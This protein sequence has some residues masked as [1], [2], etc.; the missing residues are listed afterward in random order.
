MKVTAE[1][2]RSGGWWAISVPEVPGAFTQTKRLDQV[3]AMVA[4]AVRLMFDDDA[5]DVD[6]EVV[7]HTE[8]D[9][10]LRRTMEARAEA[11]GAAARAAALTAEAAVV[12]TGSGLTVRD[13]GKLL[14]IS[15]QRVSQLV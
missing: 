15:P 1:V 6:V 5:L 11:E 9:D 7:A 12:L 4:E 3:P 8:A 2:Q 14:G 13:T 10:L